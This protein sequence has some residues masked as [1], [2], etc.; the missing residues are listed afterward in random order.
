MQKL[1]SLPKAVQD[2][3]LELA[4]IGLG[5][6]TLGRR[7]DSLSAG[8][9]QRLSLIRELQK[10]SD[11]SDPASRL[12][13]FD[14]PSS[15][16]HLKDQAQLLQLF[17][18]LAAQGSAVLYCEHSLPLLACADRVIELGPG[19]ADQGGQLIFDGTPEELLHSQTPT[20]LALAARAAT[21]FGT[22]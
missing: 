6:L 18:R 9:R 11:E 10:Q 1:T 16:L 21:E 13:L 17:E 14:E 4:G 20:G 12:Y 15:G 2:T 19:A 3:S 7:C 22:N 5:H 8:E